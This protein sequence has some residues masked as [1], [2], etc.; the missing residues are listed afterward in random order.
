MDNDSNTVDLRNQYMVVEFNFRQ[1][2]V[3]KQK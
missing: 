3:V 2:S 1:K